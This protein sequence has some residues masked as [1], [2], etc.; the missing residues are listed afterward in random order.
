MKIAICDD[1]KVFVKKI[2]EYLSEQADCSV[3]CFFSPLDLLEKYQAGER[4]DVIFLD[5]VMESLDGISLGRQIRNVDHHAVLVYLTS[6]SE[7]ALAGYEVRAFRYLLKPVSKEKV[8]QVLEEIRNELLASRK[9]L[10]KTPEF[11][12]LLH[13][14]DIQ[15]LEANDKDTT[16][17]YDKDSFALRKSLHTLES[18]LPDALFFRIHRK[19]IVNLSHVRE[20]DDV[21]LTLDGGRTLP[22]SRRQSRGFRDALTAYLDGGLHKWETY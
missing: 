11:E 5:I 22:I 19:Y 8:L 6:Y 16:I 12:L 17:Y 4:Y 13:I 9:I 14:D 7:Y 21:R 20:F 15:Y 18:L 2:S 10:F 3:E 1:E